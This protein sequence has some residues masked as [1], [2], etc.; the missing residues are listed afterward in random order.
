MF[1]YLGSP[2]GRDHAL[3]SPRVPRPFIQLVVDLRIRGGRCWCRRCTLPCLY[4]RDECYVAVVNGGENE[5]SPPSRA[6][7]GGSRTD[8]A[9]D[10]VS[11][12]ISQRVVVIG[13]CYSMFSGALVCSRSALLTHPCSV[14]PL[15]IVAYNCTNK[16]GGGLA[17]SRAK[18][19]KMGLHPCTISQLLGIRYCTLPSRSSR[20]VPLSARLTRFP[21]IGPLIIPSP[22]SCTSPIGP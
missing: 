20:T 13:P 15:M 1:C 17:R 7:T 3:V 16:G 8:L 22:P 9:L 6:T 5:M 2:F 10:P 19:A 4:E 12:Y 11:R 18:Q 14:T 21:P